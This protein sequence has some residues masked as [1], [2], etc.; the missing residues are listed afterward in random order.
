MMSRT[1]FVASIVCAASLSMVACGSDDDTAAVSTPAAEPCIAATQGEPAPE[2][3]GLDEADAQ[4]AADSDGLDLRVVGEDGE[5]F[6]ITMDVREDRV[7]IELV[8]GVVV[9][10]ARF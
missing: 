1:T 9:A 6:A 8:D 7:N 2:Y 5:C 4:A 3:V 10:A